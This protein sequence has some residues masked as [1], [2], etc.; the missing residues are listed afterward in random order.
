MLRSTCYLQLGVD[1]RSQMAFSLVWTR[2]SSVVI[3]R[4]WSASWCCP[5]ASLALLRSS[6]I[7]DGSEPPTLMTWFPLIF[8]LV[9][10]RSSLS[11]ASSSSWGGSCGCDPLIALGSFLLG[12]SAE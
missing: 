10:E 9:W 2:Y 1:T 8:L 11:R 6:F 12:A 4:S 3:D 7:G 5:S